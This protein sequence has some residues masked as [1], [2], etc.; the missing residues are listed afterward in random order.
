M[1]STAIVDRG[2][3]P[4]AS[5]ERSAERGASRVTAGLSR[6]VFVQRAAGLGAATVLASCISQLAIPSPTPTPKLRRIGYLSGLAR[7]TANNYAGPF[8]EQL[9]ELG[10]V[11]GR[12]IEVIVRAAELVDS[13]LPAMAA[14][15]VALPVDVLIAEAQAAHVAA[16]DATKSVPIVITLS[17]DP[18]AAGLVTNLA[19]PGGN[20]TGVTTASLQLTGKRVELLK[21]TVPGLARI[22]IIWNANLSSMRATVKATQDGARTL[23]VETE[24]FDVHNPVELDAAVET[25]A[26]QK[27]DGFVMLT[28]LSITTPDRAQVPDIAAKYRLPQMFSDIEIVRAGGLMHFGANYASMYREAALL[29]D[30]IFRGANPGDLP[31][32]QPTQLDFIVNLQMAQRIG[33]T[34]PDSIKRQATEVI[35]NK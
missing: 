29:V 3:A 14:E 34:I 12:D 24:V 6:R 35:P 23:G 31:I 18:I 1:R 5:R 33:L 17:A 32:A 30:K 9:L 8:R 19:R 10:Y 26:R 25:M 27:L 7:T 16:R 4:M 15:L 20:I 11:E 21:E 2:R 22:G 13:R 28:G